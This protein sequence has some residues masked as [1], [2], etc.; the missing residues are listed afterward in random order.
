MNSDED[1]NE[2]ALDLIGN[3]ARR[4]LSQKATVGKDELINALELLSKSTADRRVRKNTIKAI[5]M[6]SHRVH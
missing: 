5:Q 3:I 1:D 2:I 4:L 6:L